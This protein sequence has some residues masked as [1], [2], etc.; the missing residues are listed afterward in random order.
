MGRGMALAA[1]LLVGCAAGLYLLKY[2]VAALEDER[3]RLLSALAGERQATHV[4][5][6]EWA[7]LNEPRRLAEAA[8]RHLD[9]VPLDAQTMIA[10]DDLRLR[11]ADARDG[12]E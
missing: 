1:V 9:L 7:Y 3:A 4:L 5:Q 6:S 8:R 11:S 12:A 10:L 2:E